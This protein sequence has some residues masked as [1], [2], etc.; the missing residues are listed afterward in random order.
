MKNVH[1]IKVELKGKE[2]E[3]ILNTT[4][5]EKRKEVKVDGFRK[6][7]VPKDMY[8]KKFGIES[9]YMDA[10]DKALP[11]AYTKMLKDSKL[12]PVI[13]PKVDIEHIC[14][15]DVT[16]KFTVTTRP[17]VKLG[18]YKNLKIKKEKASITKEEVTAEVDAIR[19]RM[20]DIV[21]KE[22]GKIVKGNTA[23]IDFE[24]FVDGK[25]L[26]GGSGQN[27][28]LEIGSNTFIPGFED[29]II[30]MK[31][32]EDKELNLT[33]PNE[34]V[35][36]L[37]NKDVTFKV[38]IR[39]I[40]EKVLPEINEELFLDLGYEGV[41]TEEDFLKKVEEDLLKKKEKELEDKY[42][43]KV[44]E[45][46]IENMKV[47]INDEIIEEEISR[48]INQYSEQL[49]YQGI[50]LEQYYEFTKTTEEQL[51]EQMK[52]EALLRI[53][54]RYLLEEIVQKEKIEVTEEEAL[55]EAEKLAIMYQITKEELLSM[56]GGIEMMKYDSQMRKALDL[57]RK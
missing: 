8:I 28:P 9:L 30:G 2:W 16:F 33:F 18:E 46:A 17:E 25:E 31:A 19:T 52:P 22:D 39:E 24:G 27:F 11:T 41:K 6:G 3:E 14:E 12:Q 43:D 23:V 42:L 55:E 36:N 4:F 44:I 47:E 5:E 29:G 34:Y 53:K 35:D 21:V 54:S 10:V 56:F 7:Q 20:A 50:N 15:N 1:E 13:E 57:L 37:K 51:K 48:M 38:H 32:G 49:S 40:K 26:E 45:K